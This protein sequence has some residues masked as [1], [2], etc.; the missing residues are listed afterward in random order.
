MRNL[1][2]CLAKIFLHMT[3]WLQHGK[4]LVVISSNEELNKEARKFLQV[5]IDRSSLPKIE[6]QIVYGRHW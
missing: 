2:C 5:K 1:S 4:F 3:H 6:I